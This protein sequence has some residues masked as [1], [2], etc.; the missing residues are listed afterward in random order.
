M[1]KRLLSVLLCLL[2][3]ATLPVA[4]FAAEEEAQSLTISTTAQLL[5]FA[6]NC[7]LDSYSRGLQVRLTADIDL[8]EQNFQGIPIFCGS[9][10]GGGHIISGLNITGEGSVQGLFRYLTDTAEVKD[11]QV[12]GKVAPSGSASIVGGIAG[13]NAGTIEDCSFQGTVSGS[14]T[15]GGIVGSNALTGILQNCS[16]EGSVEGNH[17][18][19]GLA[20]ENTGVIRRCVNHASV[21]TTAQQNSVEISDITIETLTGSE[22]AA[23]VTDIGGIAGANTG[24]IRSCQNRGDIGYK[25]MGYN[26]GGIAGSHMGYITDC[27]NYGAVSGRKEV[28]G[29]VGQ[30][31]PVV[32]VEYSE[33]TLQILQQQLDTMGSLAGQTSASAQSGAAAIN[34]QIAAMEE[35]A[36]A[37]QE[38]LEQLLPTVIEP[39]EGLPEVELPD[40]DT[41]QAAQNTLS[42]SISGMQ[43]SLRSIAATTQASANAL[44]GNLQAISNQVGAMSQTVSGASENLG[45]SITDVSDADTPEDLTGK[46]ADCENQGPVLGDLNAGG[47]CGA[48]ALENDLD[49]DAD[50]QISGESS[51]NFDSMLRAVVLSCKNTGSVTAGKQN[52]GGIVGWMSMGLVKSSIN[53]GALSG[54]D[55]TGGIAG[56]S[57]GYIRGCSVKCEILADGWAG[58]IAGTGETVTDCRSMVQLEAGEKQGAVLGYAESLE[59]LSGNFYL[60]IRKDPG[61]VDGISYDGKGQALEKA[62]FL[63]LDGLNKMFR[64]V[65]VQFIFED[66]TEKTVFL[67]PGEKL[68]ESK[69]PQ[70]PEKKGY[71]A[72]WAGLESLEIAFDTVYRVEYTPLS[73]VLQ[74]SKCRENGRPVLLTEGLF[75]PESVIRADA[76]EGAPKAEGVLLEAL[77]IAVPETGENVTLRYQP[78]AAAGEELV[79]YL[80]AGEG[81]W[82]AIPFGTDGSYLVFAAP[83]GEL[84]LALF[85]LERGKL[86]WA[87]ILAAAVA[88]AALAMWLLC[89]RKKAK[90]P[91]KK[92]P[93]SENV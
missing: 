63:E 83:G 1:T 60:P 47:I 40:R 45:G 49:H 59:N 7:R 80:R 58:G 11:L 26:I 85:G 21:N 57:S 36:K 33:D 32:Y 67:T 69:I 41:L 78:P 3:A 23:T 25:H 66:G 88:V 72:R 54:G 9:F 15:V 62:A 79:L 30:M 31:E 71:T 28:G 70:I 12:E 17:F 81:D 37:A 86:P 93:V 14:D 43:G 4:A 64:T 52:T 13:S 53:S 18:A 42:G 91:K 2:L 20:G 22:S 10:D 87:V 76:S 82:Q 34:S 6:E 51:L 35:Q 74:S 48:I 8:K 55:Y 56:S 73:T 77:S 5:E 44:T 50:I 39:E 92:Q 75:P 29:I 90:A 19:G 65:T 16:M 38:A 24:V 46:L 84:S 68:K 89:R 27:E 61:G